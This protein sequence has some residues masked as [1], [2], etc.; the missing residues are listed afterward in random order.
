MI[1]GPKLFIDACVARPLNHRILVHYRSVFPALQITHLT[2]VY[3]QSRCDSVWVKNLAAEGGWIVITADHGRDKS[4]P[5]L[6]QL[7]GEYGLTCVTMT[8]TL[9]QKGVAMHQAVL[10]EILRNME[11]IY[12]GACG[13]G[14]P[15]RPNPGKRRLGKVCFAHQ[16]PYRC[17]FIDPSTPYSPPNVSASATAFRMALDL[18]TVSWNSASGVESF[19]QPPPACT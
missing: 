10:H 11:P 8:S 18:L 15:H 16:P 9:H 12:R 1:P 5:M 6:P 3:R 7:C 17:S 13:N 14:H 4:Q 2:D 19:T